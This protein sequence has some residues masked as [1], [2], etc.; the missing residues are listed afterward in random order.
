M[1]KE[2]FWR[3]SKGG[4]MI[5]SW[6]CFYNLHQPLNKSQSFERNSLKH[7]GRLRTVYWLSLYH[8]VRNSE[9]SRL[10]RNFT[11]ELADWDVDSSVYK[12]RLKTK[13]D[14]W[15]S[16]LWTQRRQNFRTCDSYHRRRLPWIPFKTHWKTSLQAELESSLM[17]ALF[18]KW[19]WL[20]YL[21]NS[22]CKFNW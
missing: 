8:G 10:Y 16:F 9:Q 4:E 11:N 6:N 3:R 2:N 17:R 7:L 21:P 15:N 5:T 1:I 22:Q 18:E 12:D 13:T 20:Y 14:P 19:K